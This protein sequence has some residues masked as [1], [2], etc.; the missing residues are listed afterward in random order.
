MVRCAKKNFQIFLLIAIELTVLS[1]FSQKKGLRPLGVKMN[2]FILLKC[3]LWGLP[4][5]Y[6]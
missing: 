4:S 3:V 2:D 5:T 6:F 1:V